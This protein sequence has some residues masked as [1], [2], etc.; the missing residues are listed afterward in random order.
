MNSLGARQ[1]EGSL[2]DDWGTEPSS[3]L[4][5]KENQMA[6]LKGAAGLEGGEIEEQVNV[7]T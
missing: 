3:E 2:K 1:R 6:R 7:T 4:S 5:L